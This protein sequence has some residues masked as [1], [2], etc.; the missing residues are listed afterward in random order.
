MGKRI[1]IRLPDMTAE[2]LRAESE[3]TDKTIS[4]V[5]REMLDA[6]LLTKAA[7]AG[8]SPDEATFGSQP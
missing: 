4:D 3:R 8:V 7:P 5:V 6:G 2:C 1:T